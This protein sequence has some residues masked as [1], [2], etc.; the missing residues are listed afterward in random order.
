[1]PPPIGRPIQNVRV[2][3]LDVGRQR[4]PVGVPGELCVA[5]RSLARGYH[6]RPELTDEKF[7]RDPFGTPGARMYATG[8]LVRWRPDGQLEF[9]GRMDGQVKVRGFRI[10]LGEIETVLARH[11]DVL[12]ACCVIRHDE[13]GEARLAAWAVRREGAAASSEDLRNHLRGLVPEY[14][15]PSALAWIDRL[16]LTPNGKVD[17]DGLPEPDFEAGAEAAF[18]A[19]EGELEEKIA[20]VWRDVLD[21]ERVSAAANFFDVGG[22]SLLLARLQA[23]LEPV[24]ERGG[25]AELSIVELFQFPTIASLAAHVA[26]RGASDGALSQSVDRAAD[27]RARLSRRRIRR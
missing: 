27:R 20:A 3:V 17:R 12:E 16:P 21:L 8:D 1:M 26:D 10:E 22:H 19:P 2:H 24:L 25:A 23:K 4:L 9:L 7:P 5:G 6:G 11:P 18:V 14:M 13:G 15:V